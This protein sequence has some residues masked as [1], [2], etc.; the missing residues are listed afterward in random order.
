MARNQSSDNGS[1]P[2]PISGHRLFP[3]IGA[4]VGAALLG[5]AGALVP[6]SLFDSLVAAS[7]IAGLI[8][9]AA[10]PL[11]EGARLLIAGVAA[12][13]GGRLGLGLARKIAVAQ[14]N[15]QPTSSD[16]MARIK[17]IRPVAAE[18][19]RGDG[20]FAYPAFAEE[21]VPEP[22]LRSAPEFEDGPARAPYFE[23][24]EEIAWNDPAPGPA[25]GAASEWED[26]TSFDPAPE[27]APPPGFGYPRDTGGGK[28]GAGYAPL[29]PAAPASPPQGD[30]ASPLPLGRRGPGALQ[31][32]PDN[33]F[34]AP[35]MPAAAVEPGLMQR[36]QALQ[37]VQPA[38]RPSIPEVNPPRDGAEGATEPRIA[39]APIAPSFGATFE[40][41]PAQ[42]GVGA[43]L[44][45]GEPFTQETGDASFT[46]ESDGDESIST[47]SADLRAQGE[48][49]ND[50][51]SEESAFGD[52][53]FDDE[54]EAP[55]IDATL[56][57]FRD[58]ARDYTG[59]DDGE[60]EEGEEEDGIAGQSY[61]SLLGMTV[62]RRA[63]DEPIELVGFDGET[64]S[65]ADT[66]LPLMDEAAIDPELASPLVVHRRVGGAS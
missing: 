29:P 59:G 44:R 41:E 35:R 46:E 34:R 6:G 61:G 60:E 56:G 11:G 43:R 22:A 25:P 18:D 5:I 23:Q 13:L 7:G 26:E 16:R 52:D 38:I 62:R 15:A 54:G 12:L 27:P 24:E 21:P 31:D 8:P 48:D 40:D 2:A 1:N 64:M 42:E 50:D 30:S 3:A 36:L 63:A 28:V 45:G 57:A 14:F 47:Q 66:E 19:E 58:Y 65:D 33:A 4:I 49:W 10:P 53:G 20:G 39:P 9:A 51:W 55:I 17:G 37:G 32:G